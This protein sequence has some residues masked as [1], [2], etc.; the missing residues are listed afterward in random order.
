MR[1]RGHALVIGRPARVLNALK[2]LGSAPTTG[3]MPVAPRLS[4]LIPT[5]C[6]AKDVEHLLR[7]LAAQPA[8]AAVAVPILVSDNA[9]TDCTAATVAGLQAELASTDLRLHV[10]PE[11]LGAVENI[12]WLARNAPESE[13]VWVIGDDDVPE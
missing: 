12:S 5:Y 7:A 2:R 13:Y 1:G 8:V 11:N 10:Q 6:R 9:S 3:A 4:V